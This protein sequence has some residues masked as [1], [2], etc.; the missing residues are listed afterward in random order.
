M[1]SLSA[2]ALHRAPLPRLQVDQVDSENCCGSEN[3]KPPKFFLNMKGHRSTFKY[4]FK[5][6]HGSHIN[7]YIFK[8]ALS[9]YC[10][11]NCEYLITFTKICLYVPNILP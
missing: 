9:Q 7:F 3:Q 6:I 11:S 2:W 5:K 8:Y 1:S 4:F 10:Y